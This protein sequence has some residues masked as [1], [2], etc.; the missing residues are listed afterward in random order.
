MRDAINPDGGPSACMA[1]GRPGGPD[2]HR[3]S[4]LIPAPR[5]TAVRT[6]VGMA[7]VYLLLDEDGAIRWANDA[8]LRLFR[9]GGATQVAGIDL[10]ELVHHDD[11]QMLAAAI[12]EARRGAGSVE[13][14][15]H[16]QHRQ[17]DQDG[18]EPYVHVVMA[19]GD[20]AGGHPDAEVHPGIVVQGWDISALVMRMH[21]LEQRAYRDPLTGLVN[22]TT[23]DDRLRHEIAR[24]TRTG[25]DVAVLF[26]DIDNFKAVN[27]TYGHEAGD[28]VLLHVSHCMTDALRPADT[29]ARMGGDEFAVICPDLTGPQHVMAVADRL[30]VATAEPLSI[31]DHQLSVS[32]SIG[33]AFGMDNDQDDPAASLLRRADSAMYDLKRVNPSPNPS[34]IEKSP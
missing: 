33:V 30:R 2:P 29:L 6:A 26:A 14:L 18:G 20:P 23:F 10:V 25:M 1:A 32:L 22:R 19:V 15:V 28:H 16:L 9:H 4:G 27:D 11:H 5:A 7:M 13:V 17:A 12:G 3:L 8:A 21:E 34:R 31:H 24:S